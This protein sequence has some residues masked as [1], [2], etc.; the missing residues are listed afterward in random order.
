MD[1]KG[2]ALRTSRLQDPRP[3]SMMVV[4]GDKDGDEPTRTVRAV[5]GDGTEVAFT[6]ASRR[7]WWTTLPVW[8]SL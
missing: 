1:A 6:L 5:R 3:R 7:W 4:T 8:W 2:A